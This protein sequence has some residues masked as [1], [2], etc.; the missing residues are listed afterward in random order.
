M[1]AVKIWGGLGNQ[2][3]QYAFGYSL[4]KVKQAELMLDTHFYTHQPKHVGKRN[5]KLDQLRIEKGEIMNEIPF[6]VR[7]LEN[8]YINKAIRVFPTFS[9]KAGSEIT[10][11]KETRQTFL[12]HIFNIDCK[13][14]YVDGYWQTTKYFSDFRKELIL[15]FKPTY[16][17]LQEVKDTLDEIS[18]TNSVAVH[19]RRADYINSR[20]RTIGHYTRPQYYH[21]AISKISREQNNPVFFFFSDDMDWVR[22]E[23]GD[24]INSR[25]VQF[26]TL[27]ND[28]DDLMCMAKCT[29]SIMS[30]STFSW[31]GAWLKEN[32][33]E[34]MVIA[35][36]GNYFNQYF[37]EPNWLQI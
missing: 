29:H 34:S 26:N 31:W 11:V 19:I 4:A 12:D 15:Q 23:F 24:A 35:P 28:I 8:K 22:N 10:F 21:D 2:L 16:H 5:F 6:G 30:A 18:Q 1:I 14:L 20:G 3:F 36:R 13:N 32:P 25:F 37:L 7:I 9:I 33:E 27:H 17:Y